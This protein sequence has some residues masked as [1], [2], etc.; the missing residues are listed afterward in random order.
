MSAREDEDWDEDSRGSEPMAFIM[1]QLFLSGLSTDLLSEE[2]GSLPDV[3]EEGVDAEGKDAP[4][5]VDRSLV[6]DRY[7]PATVLPE[8]LGSAGIALEGFEHP[9]SS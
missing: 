5:V 2:E 9:P 7:H 3:D 4:S 1:N 6:K 8:E